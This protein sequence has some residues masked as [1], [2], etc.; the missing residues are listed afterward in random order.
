MITELP[1]EN[2]NQQQETQVDEGEDI[3]SQLWGSLGQGSRENLSNSTSMTFTF[4]C[5]NLTDM[6]SSTSRLRYQKRA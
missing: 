2:M 4:T 1:D 5:T 6:M 3:A